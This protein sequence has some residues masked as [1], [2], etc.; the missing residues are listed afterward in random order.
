MFWF[1]VESWYFQTPAEIMMSV[2]QRMK[3]HVINQ[4]LDESIEM[5]HYII[6]PVNHQQLTDLTSFRN[7]NDKLRL[8]NQKPNT[9]SITNL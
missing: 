9:N 5:S 8:A 3:A 6:S 7:Y 1:K 2:D 4:L